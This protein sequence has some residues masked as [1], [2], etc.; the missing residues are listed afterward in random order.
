MGWFACSLALVSFMEL[1]YYFLNDNDQRIN[2][3][4]VATDQDIKFKIG[5][6]LVQDVDKNQ[7]DWI[8]K[9]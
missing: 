9:Q 6:L 3:G 5:G 2:L 8:K 7:L 4:A 1:N